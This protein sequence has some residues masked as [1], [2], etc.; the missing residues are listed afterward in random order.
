MSASQENREK[1][2]ASI[3]GKESATADWMEKIENSNT[4]QASTTEALQKLN[5]LIAG[6][7]GS[8][9]F[10][11]DNFD[12]RKEARTSEVEGLKNAKAVLSGAGFG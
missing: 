3:T 2:A 7:H 4:D 10:L 11:V 1:M 6:L 12:T 8:C 9:D 5:D